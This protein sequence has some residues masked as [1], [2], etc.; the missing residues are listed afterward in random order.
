[1]NWK[2]HKTAA[3]TEFRNFIA[4]YPDNPKAKE[5]HKHLKELGLESATPP[6]PRGK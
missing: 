5:A 1:M 2:G 3:G 4:N 6:R